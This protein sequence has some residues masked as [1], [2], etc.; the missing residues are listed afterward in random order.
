MIVERRA[1]WNILWPIQRI[2]VCETSIVPEG[3]YARCRAVFGQ[4]FFGP[5]VR[6]AFFSCWARPCF[7]PVTSKTVDKDDTTILLAEEKCCG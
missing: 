1:N 6:V 7:D 2:E 4:E 5:E 3:H